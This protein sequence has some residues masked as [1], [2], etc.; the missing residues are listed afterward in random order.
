M[1]ERKKQHFWTK[2]M[3]L[4]EIQ[5]GRTL[6]Q[7]MSLKELQYSSENNA[8]YSVYSLFHH[9][10]CQPITSLFQCLLWQLW[11]KH[12]ACRRD[13]KEM[14]LLLF[15]ILLVI[16]K[17]TFKSSKLAVCVCAR[18]PVPAGVQG[19]EREG[20]G[21][22]PQGE[23]QCDA[24]GELSCRLALSSQVRVNLTA[25]SVLLSGVLNR[26]PVL[27]GWV[28]DEE[29]VVNRTASHRGQHR[30]ILKMRE[31]YK[32]IIK[33]IK[34]REFGKSQSFFI[35]M[36]IFSGIT[37]SDLM[38]QQPKGNQCHNSS[39]LWLLRLLLYL[40]GKRGEIQ[41]GQ[42]FEEYFVSAA[43]SLQKQ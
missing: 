29:S 17:L 30:R 33:F 11:H 21:Q 36:K 22:R 14:T 20:E 6:I 40:V 23:T 19:K 37:W 34:S 3:F 4:F 24:G 12:K 28:E 16:I 9:Q 35:H 32:K 27:C 38:L 18:L 8:A 2:N 1:A 39:W 15:C 5:W 13:T 41:I 10:L 25:V 26:R 31:R 43:I 42:V 7:A